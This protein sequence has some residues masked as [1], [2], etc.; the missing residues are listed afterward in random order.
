M[1]PNDIATKQDIQELAVMIRNLDKKIT[2]PDKV[3]TYSVN[4]LAKLGT[5][6]RGTRIRSLIK[7]GL[8][9]TT[10]GGRI[11]QTEINNFLNNQ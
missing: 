1:N 10:K 7:K 5:I 3:K 11:S 9:R 2:A 4:E 6:G 8:L